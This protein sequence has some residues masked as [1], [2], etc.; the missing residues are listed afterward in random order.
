LEDYFSLDTRLGIPIPSPQ[1]D[2]DHY[3]EKTQH[4]ILLYWEGIRGRIPDR[5]SLIEEEITNKLTEMS[6]EHDFKRTCHLNNEIAELA[7]IIND[8]WIWYRKH[9]PITDRKL[10]V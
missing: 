6:N 7:S 5:I 2:L 9:E 8:L 10:Y 3:C 1:K 4:A